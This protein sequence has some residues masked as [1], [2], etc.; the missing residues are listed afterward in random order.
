VEHVYAGQARQAVGQLA[1]AVGAAVVDHQH[2]DA[3]V[4]LE[5]GV[6]DRLDVLRSL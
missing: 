5:H 6:D 2:I 3:R 4:G 1:R